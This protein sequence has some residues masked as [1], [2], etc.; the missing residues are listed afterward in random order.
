M[1]NLFILKSPLQIINAFEAVA[2]FN[3]S[4]NIFV[5]IYT[6]SLANENQ[7][8]EIINSTSTHDIKV[9]H[10]KKE[11][12]SKFLKYV[13]LI[14][15][16]KKD[17]YNYI[18]L[19]E[20]GKFHKVLLANIKKEKVFLLDDGAGTVSFYN[21][22]IKTGK[23]NK[24]KFKEIRFL[25]FGLKVKVKDKMN[26][27]TY[28]DLEPVHGVEVIKNRLTNLKKS[29]QKEN[30][31]DSDVIYFIGQPLDDAN[32]INVDIYKEI[33]EKLIIMFQ[34]KIVYIPHRFESDNLKKAISL[35]D[36]KLFEINNIN[37]PI[38]VYFIEQKIYP[39]HI[40]S[41]FSTALTT[42]GMI[43]EEANINIIKIPE[44]DF[45]KTYF[46]SYLREFYEIS[47]KNKM[48]TFKE[49]GIIK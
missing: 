47:D 10:V 25:I 7:M 22:T 35:I 11:F 34:K 29:Y 9:I 21:E 12:K 18:F 6:D 17:K 33:L 38:E 24:Y 31:Q 1:K 3:L 46:N 43:Y 2:H 28:Y 13:K 14:K 8:R 40:I 37:K 45:N 42:L 48:I 39:K 20:I 41:S 32:I 49:L 44:N 23:Y 19:G 15:E 16:F 26:L 27:F 30:I 5:L 36:D 4:N